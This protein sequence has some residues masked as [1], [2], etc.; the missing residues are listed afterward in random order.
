MSAQDKTITEAEAIT[1]TTAYRGRMPAGSTR[2]FLIPLA[3]LQG[4]INE[5]QGQGGSPMAR[6][7]LAYDAATGKDKL[8]FCGTTQD[9]ATPG[10]TIYRDMLP[11]TAPGNQLWDFTEPC[12]SACDPSSPLNQ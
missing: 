10:T 4:L 3:D 2:A 7:Y 5:I 1:W 6:G 12:P 11:S 8:V 9:N